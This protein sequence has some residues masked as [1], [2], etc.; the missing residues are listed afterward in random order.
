VR[1]TIAL[2]TLLLVIAPAATAQWTS[3]RPDGHAPIGVM[4]DHRHEAGEVMLSYR[5][6]HMWMEG[7]RD[8]TSA[9]GDADI[10]SATGPYGF[11]ATPTEMRMQMHMLGVMFAPADGI[12]LLGMA[13]Y[14]RSSMDHL[15]RNGNVFTTESSGIGDLSVGAMIGLADFGRQSLHANLSLRVPTGSIERMDVIPA[16]AP[17]EVVLPYPMQTGS[18]SWGVP[19]GLT[20]LGQTDDWSW[21]GQ[22]TAAFQL[23]T[24]DRDYKL[25][26]RYEGTFW[27]AR[28]LG[29]QLSFSLRAVASRVENIEGAD[30]D[31]N[32]MMVPTADPNLRAGTRIDG[33]LGINFSVPRAKGLRFAIE[34][35]LP[36]YRN[37]TGPQLETDWIIVA[38]I[39]LVP[40][41]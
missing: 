23:N 10:V 36:V 34:G 28:R 14:L 33:A 30:P 40:V 11:M 12:T 32:P 6:M 4:G 3:S 1:T 22:G 15:L 37:L 26:N 2:S 29:P 17:N 8:G 38:G 20:Y 41:K 5:F 13:P 39:Q 16:S 35:L 31:L 18:G 21:G 25:G 24:N 19:V 9:I 7:S 27:G